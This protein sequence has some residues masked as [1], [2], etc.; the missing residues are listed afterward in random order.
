MGNQLQTSKGDKTLLT[1]LAQG[2]T[3]DGKIDT[4]GVDR[5]G[6]NMY[7]QKFKSS[8]KEANYGELIKIPNSDRIVAM[9]ERDMRGTVTSIAVA[10][11]LAIETLNLK[12]TMTPIQIVDCA[13]VI[14]DSAKEDKIAMEDVLVF[15][16]KL[17]RGQYG[18]L[19][20]V[21]D[22]AKLLGFFDKFRDERYLEAV[23]IRDAKTQEF[24][25]LGDANTYERENPTD[26][27]PFGQY[28]QHMR[29]KVQTKNDERRSKNG[30]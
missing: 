2:I 18:E 30:R 15:L 13:E 7:L 9:A 6:M 8:E 4:T 14:V 12:I 25:E 21:I 29:Q 19:Y 10:L 20:G 11:T 24:K 5:V 16:Q 23:R 27:S 26:A 3:K 28:M 17:T 1:Y 22:Q